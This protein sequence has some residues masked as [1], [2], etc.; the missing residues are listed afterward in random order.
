M[1]PRSLPWSLHENPLLAQWVDFGEAGV[2]RVFSA[3]VELGQGIVT[4]LAQ[5]AAEELRLPLSQVVVVSGDTRRCPNE[6]YTAGSMSIEVGGTSLRMACADARRAIE[7]QAARM[8]HAELGRVTADAGRIFVDGAPSELDYW[9]V[10]AQVDWK[11]PVAGTAELTPPERARFIGKSVARLDLPG[12]VVGSAFIH[13]LDLP[14]MLHGRVLRPPSYGARLESLDQAAAERLPGVAK[15]WLSGDF[16]GVCCEREY[17]A[18]KALEALRAGARW[19][20]SEVPLGAPNWRELLLSLRSIDSESEVGT[21]PAVAAT[22]RRV[23]A[24]YSRPLLAH[25]SMAPSCALACFDDGRLTVWTHSQGVFPLRGALATALGLDEQRIA[26][27]HVQG[28]GVYGHNGADDAALD[29]A[30][31]ARQVPS[32]PVRVQWMRDDELAWSPFGS[33]MVVKIDGALTASG[34]IADWSTQVWSGPHGQRPS[35]GGAVNLLAA[36]H[37]D[38]PIPF[39]DAYETMSGFAGSVRNSEPPYDVAHR[40]I[41]L[42]SLP[43]LPFRTSSLRT[44][45]G[46]ANVFASESFM[47]ELADAAG[48][49]PVQFRLRH[50]TDPRAR[51]VIETAARLSGWQAGAQR[52]RGSAAGIG[53]TRYKNTAAYVAVVARVEVRESV[54]VSKVWCAVDAGLAINPDGIINQ[55]EGGIVQSI[56]WTLNEQVGFDGRRVTT[57]SWEEYPILH[58]DEVPEVEVELIDSSDCPP[59]GVGEAAQGPAAAAVGNA[60]ARALDFRIRDLP[61]TRERII[62]AGA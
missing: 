59:L 47:D 15:I 25:A 34:E 32:R 30:L 18:I 43:G 11:R 9:Q 1:S 58:F 61:I 14:G 16:A 10:A 8:L 52:G 13:D 22:A 5:I 19:I 48:A 50:L 36:A 3:K 42:H 35:R 60:V 37:V 40:K 2:A 27:I 23:S 6:S 17:Q 12:K 53:F 26:V 51:R 21:L 46:Y 39:P 38:P 54:R 29:A 49:D 20:E 31:L 44:L 56:S 24:T 7:E 62:A 55:I 4:A 33:P 57:R 28:A 41:V 45:G